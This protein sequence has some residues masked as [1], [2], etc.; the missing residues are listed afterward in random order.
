M[1]ILNDIRKRVY[2]YWA[3]VFLNKNKLYADYEIGEYT[4]GNPIVLA[5]DKNTRLK[6]GRFCSIAKDVTIMLGGEHHTNWVTTYPFGDFFNELDR[7]E[8]YA[9]SKGDVTIGNDVWIGHGAMILS[10]VSIGHGAVIAANSTVTKNVPPY[11]IVGGNPAKI[12][13][14]RFNENQIRQLLKIEWWNWSIEKI[15]DN[16]SDLLSDDI[17]DFLSKYDD[18]EK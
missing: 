12:I 4:Y 6:I 5:H 2:S 14:Y 8:S 3:P 1:R 11:A 16:C 9:K 17:S 10:G 7:R 18:C 13:R 15:L